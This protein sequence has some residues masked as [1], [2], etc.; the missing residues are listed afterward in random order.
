M[1]NKNLLKEIKPYLIITFGM[2]IYSFAATG[3]LVPHK[4]VGGGA[5]GISTVLFYLFGIPVGVGYA[6]V[7]I[8]LLV[9][10]MKILGPKFGIKTIFAIAVGSIFL[11]IMQPLMPV[12]GI[13]PDEKFMS[14]IIAAMLTGLGIGIAISVGGSTGGTDIIA[15]LVTKYH[16]VSPGKILMFCDFCVIAMTLLIYD[17]IDREAVGGLIYGYVMMGI[18]SF[19]VDYVLTGKTQSAQLFIFTDKFDEVARELTNQVH[20]GV[21]LIDAKGWYSGQDKKIILIV[22]RKHEASD[23]LR[24]AK[25][26]DP[27]VFM[28]MAPVMGVFGKGFDEVKGVK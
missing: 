22:A 12:D 24:I 23:V 4:I 1:K 19:T 2:L 13:L 7:N 27:N 15:M 5:T 26:V 16:N 21:T 28:T 6:L 10:A 3:F 11:G 8:I 14:T 18:V 20:R 25:Q 17:H 9:I